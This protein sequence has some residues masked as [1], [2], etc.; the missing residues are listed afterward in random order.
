MELGDRTVELAWKD[1]PSWHHP[2]RGF[3]FEKKE[4]FVQA[5]SIGEA[6]AYGTE[7]TVNAL[8]M[9]FQFI[10]KVSSQQ[11]SPRLMGGPITIVRVAYQAASS[12]FSDLL[13][14]LCLISANL[15]VI[16]FLPIPGARRWPHGLP[17]L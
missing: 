7:E 3:V 10:G 1:D 2:E 14:F 17:R 12:R 8:L 13:L 5:G 4:T 15:A 11:V 6:V 9:V 16:N